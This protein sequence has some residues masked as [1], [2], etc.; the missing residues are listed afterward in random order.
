MSLFAKAS[1]AQLEDAWTR[2]DEKPEYVFLR[3]PETGLVMLRGRAGGGGTAFNMGEIT[4]TRCSVRLADGAVGHGYVAGR[5][6]RHAEL[7]AVFDALM[8]ADEHRRKLEDALATPIE[9]RLASRRRDV[10]ARTAATRVD[11]FTLV[12]GEGDQ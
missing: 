1:T 9:S 4:V 10:A 12:R 3:R 5:G 6:R 2:Y 11:F 7:A 8:Q